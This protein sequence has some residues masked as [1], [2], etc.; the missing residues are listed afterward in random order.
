MDEAILFYILQFLVAIAFFALL[1]YIAKR[2]ANSDKLM[3]GFKNSRFLN[4]LEYLPSEEISSLKQVFFL[5]MILIFVVII[6]YLIFDWNDGLYFISILD[7][8]ISLY[9]AVTMGKDQLKD[10]ILLFL[11]IPFGSIN[12]ILF[13]TT[14]GWHDILHIF[15]YLYFIKVYYRKFVQYTENHDLGITIILLFSIILVSFLFTILVEEVSP[16]DSITIVSNAFTSNSFEVSGKTMA[17]KLDSLLLAWG[18]FILSS[19]GTATLAVSMVM[20]R[21]DNQFDRLED[22]IKNKKKE[23]KD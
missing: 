7:T 11:L 21:A 4:P 9:L 10:K 22:L 14:I 6:L 8:I 3:N 16:M 13:G 18:G 12:I 20:R 5:I 1:Y 15:A 17:G 23:K 2:I 19:V